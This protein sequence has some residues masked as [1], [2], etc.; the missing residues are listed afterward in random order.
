VQQCV[1]AGGCASGKIDV[2]GIGREAVT[3]L[4]RLAMLLETKICGKSELEKFTKNFVH[5][6]QTKRM[7]YCH[8]DDNRA[9]AASQGWRQG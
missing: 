5:E 2:G 1:D 9:V 3:F 6:I 4:G 8:G 7:E